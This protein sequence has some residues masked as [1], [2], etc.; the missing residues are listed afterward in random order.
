MKILTRYVVRE[1]VGPLVFSLSALTIL[2]LLNQVAKQFGNLVGKGLSWGVIGEFFLLSVPFIVAM[3]LP[4]AVLVAVLYTFSRMAA[5]NEVTALRATGVSP[6]RLMR[7]LFVAGAVLGLVM[8]EFNDQLLPRS[9]HRLRTL[10]TDIARKKPTFALR[11][12]VINEV[13]PG[14]LYL[15]TSHI[16][17]ATDRLREVT[18]WDFGDPLHRRTIYADSGRMGLT[19][20]HRDLQMILYSGY[21][22]EMPRETPEQLQR[23]YFT[24]DLVRVHGVANAFEAT[25]RDDYRSEREMGICEMERNRVT[26][27]KEIIASR[28]DF[29]DALRRTTHRLV[30]GQSGASLPRREYAGRPTVAGVYCQ[31]SDATWRLIAARLGRT[32]PPSDSA[33]TS[34]P[35]KKARVPASPTLPGTAT[36]P[37]STATPPAPATASAKSTATRKSAA[38]A[39][40]T[41]SVARPRGAAM[42]SPRQGAQAAI[43]QVIRQARDSAAR[44]NASHPPSAIAAGDSAVSPESTEAGAD[45]VERGADFG[46]RAFRNIPELTPTAAVAQ[47]DVMRTREVDA[48]QAEATY[49]VEIQKKF[50]LAAACVVFVIFGA[51]VGLR[52]PRGGVGLVIGISMSVFA[53]YYVGLIA[54]EALADKLL[55]NPTLAMWIA[56]IVFTVIG[57]VMMFRVRRNAPTSRGG[58]IGEALTAAR[59]AL[60]RAL[61]RERR[62]VPQRSVA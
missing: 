57:A 40:S 17:Q 48:R 43:P 8:L 46:R 56:N 18:I 50:A 7:P 53:I 35:P 41:P 51:P 13:S 44:I 4:M 31:L 39:T 12:Q 58:E 55:V 1:H 21:S 29:A 62:A 59:D 6:L 49:A 32:L 47:L 61:G 36:T 9:N 15:R 42:P 19:P 33:A 52:F 45:Q 11:E 30:T 5:E 54:G 16:E 24:D 22:L 10:Q 3:T 26:H 37:P 60:R 14:K 2:L 23:V 27:A 28:E 34:R 20:D 25:Q 38:T